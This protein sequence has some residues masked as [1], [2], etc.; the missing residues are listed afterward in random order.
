MLKS[1][2]FLLKRL[3]LQKYRLIL[4][5]LGIVIMFFGAPVISVAGA[6]SEDSLQSLVAKEPENPRHWFA[7]GALALSNNQVDLAKGYFDEAVKTKHQDEKI[8]L[9]IGELW[10]GVNLTRQCLAYWMPNLKL[11]N[12]DQLERLQAALERDKMLSVQLTVLRFM[13]EQSHTF[14]PF[15]KKASMLAF[16]Q[17]DYKLCQAILS[18]FME[19]I[20]FES[21]RRYLLS[22]LYLNG[23]AD[24]KILTTLQKKFPQE[25]IALLA[26]VQLALFGQWKD[27]R[28][29]ANKN[30][31][32]TVTRE[33]YHYIKAMDAAA[34]DNSEE[35]VDEFQKALETAND[36][37]KAV[38]TVDL[39]RQFA[40][41]GNKFQGD[42]VWDSLKTNYTDPFQQEF[43]ASQLKMRGYEKQ[44]KYFYRSVLRNHPNSIAA[45]TNLWDDFMDQENFTVLDGHLR[46]ILGED[47]YSCNGNLLAMKFQ[48]KQGKLKEVLPYGRNAIVYCY[49]SVEPYFY[50]G[51]AYASLSLPDE[52]KGY[53]VQYVKKGGD[54]NRIPVNFR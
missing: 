12:A 41:T 15:P 46:L 49:E 28:Y 43:V 25:E 20:D 40:S 51:S 11:L 16:G 23:G 35:A 37:I 53:F 3:S 27:V 45:V 4:G 14:M 6:L 34:E 24:P 9:Q 33:L 30:K 26:N 19:Q 32:S 21:A 31:N 50:M 17:G 7:L 1:P 38:I 13:A 10:L 36:Q 47:P 22:S 18:G 52:A 42:Q 29:F 54:K 8:I 48:L 2:W 44:A 5:G 39:Y